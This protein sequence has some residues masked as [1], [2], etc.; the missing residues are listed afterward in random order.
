LN[1]VKK[2][3]AG[4]IL[5]QYSYA[6]DLAGNRVSAQTNGT[7]LATA[8]NSLNQGGAQTAGGS[9]FW[10]GH[11]NKPLYS[12]TLNGQPALVSG[13]THFSGSV[14]VMAGTNA[15]QVAAEDTSANVTTNNFHVVIPAGSASAPTYDLDGN[16]TGD[17]QGNTYAW[18]A[19]NELVMITYPGGAT[20]KF[21]YDG[22]GRRASIVET[23]T[24]GTI[25]STK[26]FVFDG[27]NP[28]EER[29]ASDSVTK[30]FFAQGVQIGATNYFYTRDH[31]GS[32]RELI[33]ASASIV[34]R[35]D[36]DPWGQMTLVQG[37]LISDFGYAGMYFNRPSGLNLTMF[38]GYIPPACRWLSRDPLNSA[39]M[40]QGPNLYEYCSNDPLGKIDPLG[41][42]A[43]VIGAAIETIV[44]PGGGTAVG[45]GAGVIID[46]AASGA[47]VAG[48]WKLCHLK[49]DEDK[50][51]CRAQCNEDWYAGEKECLQKPEPYRTKCLNDIQDQLNKCIRKCN[52]SWF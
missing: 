27:F 49:S 51:K 1:G 18:D 4:N 47:L 37:T 8:F 3:T 24:N 43:T 20:S 42:D 28:V 26:Q 13:S 9:L 50:R 16:T 41:Q 23:A 31:L 25:T 40:K 32:I 19:K 33:D 7:V 38:R 48:I 2:D 21:T 17:A 10:Q 11:S 44:E 15:V 35:L 36:Y 52:G 30:R 12:V 34:S 22:L 46:A 6:Y 14:P 5:A 29:D 39:E 45:A